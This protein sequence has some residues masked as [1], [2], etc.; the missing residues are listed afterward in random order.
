[1]MTERR[2]WL[3]GVAEM[4]SDT[5]VRMA[6]ADCAASLVAGNN[7]LGKVRGACAESLEETAA[8]SCTR[9][10]TQEQQAGCSKARSP[11]WA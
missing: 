11:S 2:I 10:S 9:V 8:P 7:R 1:M 6:E 5:A 3:V 4:G